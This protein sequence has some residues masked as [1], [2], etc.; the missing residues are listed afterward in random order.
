MQE[1]IARLRERREAFRPP[2]TDDEL[3]SL[4]DVLGAELPRAVR[5]LY[6]DHGG[7]D[8]AP[9][10]LPMRLYVPAEA[11]DAITRWREF[12]VPFEDAELGVFWSD[13]NSNDAGVFV[14]GPLRD[15][16]FV[17]DH[18]DFSPEP[19]WTT[20][21]SF[22]DAL[23]D[24]R[25]EELLWSEMWT[26]YPRRPDRR[27]PADDDDLAREYFALHQRDPRSISGRIAAFRALALSVPDAHDA[28]VL[29]LLESDDMWIQERAADVLRVWGNSDG[30]LGAT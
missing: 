26:D 14:A 28:I 4:R 17:I 13:E 9:S 11:A 6:A 10:S 22:Y 19:R 20:V 12:G 23:L 27:Y 29:T 30:G 21:E 8:P 25:D 3:S 2:A 15:R 16:G 7:L 5:A 18:E 24:G 1:Q